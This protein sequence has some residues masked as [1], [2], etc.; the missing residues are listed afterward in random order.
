[1]ATRSPRER[2]ALMLLG[3]ALAVALYAV[4]AIYAQQAGTQLRARVA[5]LRVH[6]AT[7]EQ[8]AAEYGRLRAQ[9]APQAP[10]GDL[11]VQVQAQTEAAG[12]ARALTRLDPAGANQVQFAFGAVSFSDWLAWQKRLEA[13]SIRVDNCRIEALSTPGLVSV[14]GSLGRPAGA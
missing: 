14:S 10:G 5:A 8:Q 13:L 6:A 3:C 9:S 12:L 11:R 4:F 7:L 2:K 1:M